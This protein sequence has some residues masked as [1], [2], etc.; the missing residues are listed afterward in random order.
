VKKYA[1]YPIRS[2]VTC[3]DCGQQGR[4]YRI[5]EWLGYNRRQDKN[6]QFRCEKCKDKKARE[7]KEK[8]IITTL[9]TPHTAK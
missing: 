8:F 5:A 2:G 4:G 1:F 9:Q 7:I 3:F 6:P